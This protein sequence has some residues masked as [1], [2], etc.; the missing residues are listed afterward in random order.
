MRKY[1]HF[2]MS[3]QSSMGHVSSFS[4]L[5]YLRPIHLSF[6]SLSFFPVVFT[7]LMLISGSETFNESSLSVLTESASIFLLGWGLRGGDGCWSCL[8]KEES[9]S[10]DNVIDRLLEGRTSAPENVL[11]LK[12]RER[13]GE[14]GSVSDN[15]EGERNGFTASLV[16][17]W[18]SASEKVLLLAIMTLLRGGDNC[19]GNDE[20]ET[21]NKFPLV[22]FSAF[23][24]GLGDNSP[25]KFDRLCSIWSRCLRN[26]FS[27]EF[28]SLCSSR[29]SF[30]NDAAS[31]AFRKS[32]VL[33]LLLESKMSCSL[34]G[35]ISRCVRDARKFCN[36]H[37]KQMG[38][39]FRL[40]V[41]SIQTNNKWLY[42][43]FN[44]G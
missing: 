2:L 27:S 28:H 14:S 44:K 24:R 10:A 13:G 11:L 8:V 36:D 3:S 42:N 4:S 41:L 32:K 29:S 34:L 15:E 12:T 19:S 35:F 21:D 30:F 20:V 40:L 6:V 1:L 17:D 31:C 39:H 38:L 37:L 9:G 16:T 18:Q 26:N 5:L 33:A 23:L 43:L 22:L 25:A 7:A